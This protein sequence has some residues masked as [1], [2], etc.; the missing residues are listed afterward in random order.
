M[1]RNGEMLRDAPDLVLA[2][3]NNIAES[4]GTADMIRQARRAGV[5]VWLH[6]ADGIDRT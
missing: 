2:F 4:R 6:H 3:H 5:A 1:I